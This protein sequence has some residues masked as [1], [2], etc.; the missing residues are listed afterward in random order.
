PGWLRDAY[1]HMKS[2]TCG[3][4]F[5]RA[6]A[7]W[8]ELERMY[9][10]QTPT[11]SLGAKNRPEAIGRWLR[12]DRRVLAKTPNMPNEAEYADMWWSWWGGLQ[13]G[14][15]IR[16]PSGRPCTG[17]EGPWDEL[18]VPG[19]NGML[20]VLLSLLWWHGIM[21]ET[22]GDWEAAVRDVVWV[23]QQMTGVQL[24]Q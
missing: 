13:P 10:W 24:S 7:L 14:W 15:R 16:G 5:D 22:R 2:K 1:D 11:K 8:T 18:S 21:S 12:V 19:K 20:I 23:L 3:A 9:R 6:L 4:Q 17:G